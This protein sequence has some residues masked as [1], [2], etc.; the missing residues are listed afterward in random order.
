MPYIHLGQNY[1]GIDGRIIRPHESVR[2]CNLRDAKFQCAAK[3]SSPTLIIF[4]INPNLS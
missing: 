4:W 2:F 1:R 3:L